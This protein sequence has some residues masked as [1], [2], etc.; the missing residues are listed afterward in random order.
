MIELNEKFNSIETKLTELTTLIKTKDKPFMNLDEVVAYTGIPKA[1]IYSYTSRGI[2]TYHKVSG[3]RLYF[4]VKEIDNF[5]LN[6][7]N[8]Y[9][10][11]QQIEKE[12]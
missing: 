5:I 1:T 3:R 11:K 8:K 4:S 10:S 9:K 12:I 7:N 6:R 2:L